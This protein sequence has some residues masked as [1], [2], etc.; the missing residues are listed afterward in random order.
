MVCGM[1]PS[2]PDHLRTRGAGGEFVWPLCRAHH[3]ERHQIGIRT[4]V[5]KYDLPVSFDGIYPTFVGDIPE[6]IQ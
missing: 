4:F 6:P 5:K 1:T 2:D 3:V